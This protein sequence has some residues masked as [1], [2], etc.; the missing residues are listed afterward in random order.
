[1][2]KQ[3]ITSKIFLVRHG[4]D[5]DSQV[6][7]ING[8][9]DSPLT[10]KGRSQAN[11]VASKLKPEGI[12]AIYTSP[13][14]RAFE[15]ASIIAQGL[16]VRRVHVK[17][18]LIERE[19]GILTGRPPD[20]IDDLAIKIVKFGNFRYVIDSPG[21]ETYSALWK[22]AGQVLL[23]ILDHN[24]ADTVLV[25]AHNEIIKMMRANY[26]KKGWPEELEVPP[27]DNCEVI[28]LD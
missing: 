8:R 18:D 17:N 26:F 15:T 25:V 6:S 13:L 4:E 3:L 11:A 5:L 23:S 1:M 28:K 21:V 14:R 24:Q 9:R 7:I 22:R 19:Y 16:N 12:T 10:N 27:I 2:A 20:D